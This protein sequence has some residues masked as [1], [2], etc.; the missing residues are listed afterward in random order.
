MKYILPEFMIKLNLDT[1]FYLLKEFDQEL[2]WTWYLNAQ[3][4]N[5][6]IN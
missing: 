5:L 1:R 6:N 4:K 3:R 2:Y